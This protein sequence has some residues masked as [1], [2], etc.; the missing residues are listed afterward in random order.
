[1]EYQLQIKP[2]EQK[3]GMKYIILH[4]TDIQLHTIK[5][6]ESSIGKKI[7]ESLETGHPNRIYSMLPHETAMDK[8]L[9]ILNMIKND[10]TLLKTIQDYERNGYKVLIEIPKVGL[11]IIPGKDT[12]EFLQSVNGRRIIRGL[13][14]H[15]EIN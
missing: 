4:L 5:M 8:K 11:P 9:V 7:S 6:K 15:G 3:D 1:M 10:L 13:E 12:V 2:F 14:K